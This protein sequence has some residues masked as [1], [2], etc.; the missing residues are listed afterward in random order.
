MTNQAFMTN[1]ALADGQHFV[2][3]DEKRLYGARSNWLAK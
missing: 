2:Q 3:E 1:Q